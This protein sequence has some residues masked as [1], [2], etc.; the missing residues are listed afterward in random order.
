MTQ[1][2]DPLVGFHFSI[3]IQGVVKGYFTEVSGLGSE[4]EIIEHKVIN[5][6]GHEVV[7]KIPGRSPSKGPL[8][9]SALGRAWPNRSLPVRYC[10]QVSQATNAAVPVVTHNR[11]RIQISFNTQAC[12][13]AA[14]IKNR[15]QGPA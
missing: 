8:R 15:T 14:K 1:R 3:D 12:S 4:H 9:R 5:E 10:N 2:E 11:R 13:A 7:M 6:S